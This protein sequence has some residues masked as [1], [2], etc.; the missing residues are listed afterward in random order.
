MSELL[1]P[2]TADKLAKLCGLFSSNHDGERASAAALADRL[3]RQSGLTWQDVFL[4]P[5]SS[6]L[7]SPQDEIQERIAFALA[8]ADELDD[9]QRQ[10]LHGVRRI[11]AL[12]QKQERKLDEIVASVRRAA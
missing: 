3:V 12:S 4:P 5:C 1:D 10:F 6:D 9:W 11:K 7:V 2:N 8:H